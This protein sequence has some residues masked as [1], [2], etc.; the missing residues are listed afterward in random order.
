MP[1]LISPEEARQRLGE[2]VVI[3]LEPPEVIAAKEATG[4]VADLWIFDPQTGRIQRGDRKFYALGVVH[5]PGG[6]NLGAV[7]EEPGVPEPEI[8]SRI[9]GHVIVEVN[10]HGYVHVRHANGL[11][12]EILELKPS[13]LSKGELDASGRQPD[14]I[15]EANPQRILGSIAVYRH[16]VE[17]PDKEGMLPA[18]FIAESTDGRS[19]AAVAK[20]SFV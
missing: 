8:G 2:D 16:D 14:A 15:I 5:H 9:V 17:F 12:G 18:E 1:T 6:W 7:I 13:S 19:I 20:L 4:K 10:P 11:N 3:V